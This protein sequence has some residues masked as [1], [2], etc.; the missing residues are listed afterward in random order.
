MDMRL[1][2]LSRPL[3]AGLALI[4][5]PAVLI[6]AAAQ[7]LPC[8][9]A[10]KACAIRV[11]QGHVVTKREFWIAALARPA[12]ERIGAA[13][14]ALLEYVRLD[15]IHGE[16]ANQPRQAT[17]APGFMREVRHAFD[18]LPPRV[19]ALLDQRL[20]GIYF[21]D[22]L[23]GT[24]YTDVV[25][26]ADG[27]PVAGFVVLDA[28]VL[29]RRTANAWATWK[30]NS[31]FLPAAGMRLEAGFETRRH[32]NRKNAI[33]YIL[34]HELGHV[35]SIGRDLHPPWG[36]PAAEV[37]TT[38]SYPFFS[39]SWSV[40]RGENRYVTRFDQA[41]A[42]R[43]DIVYYFGAKLAGDQ[44]AEV[45]ARLAETNFVTL[46]GST[47]PSD[48]FAEAFASYVHTVLMRKPFFIAIHRDGKRVA[49]FGAC[50]NQPRC[51]EKRNIILQLIGAK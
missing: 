37:P 17:L 32:D 3:A 4:A 34:L 46:Y 38:A 40:A 35:V 30:E 27:K 44:M 14:P 9:L 29:A 48:D 19:K 24:G 13:P 11:L 47:N 2:R 42:Q 10:D 16:L 23:G 6:Q 36:M 33:Q 43:R 31:P 41:F 22:D 12:R 26:D 50:W 8:D 5:L 39:L 21:V 28:A 15:N 51:A 1:P 49:K 18:E 25:Y 45:Y 20:A 7:L